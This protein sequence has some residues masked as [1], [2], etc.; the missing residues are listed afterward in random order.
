MQKQPNKVPK[1]FR[2]DVRVTERIF[3]EL[4][5]ITMSKKGSQPANDYRNCH[6]RNCFGNSRARE[7]GQKSGVSLTE[8]N[9]DKVAGTVRSIRRSSSWLRAIPSQDLA[10]Q[11]HYPLNLMLFP[12][13]LTHNFKVD[14]PLIHDPADN[15]RNVPE[16]IDPS[17]SYAPPIDVKM[18]NG[19]GA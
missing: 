6:L 14:C 4:R 17:R 7:A 16:A 12:I 10:N 11:V 18:V 2:L 3:R 13:G 9:N 8:I 15:D 5:R 1:S 19:V